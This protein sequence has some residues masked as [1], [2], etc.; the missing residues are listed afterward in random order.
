MVFYYINY[1]IIIFSTC[2]ENIQYKN[3]F[4]NIE[5]IIVFNRLKSVS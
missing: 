2:T 3:I 1:L 4:L 5:I